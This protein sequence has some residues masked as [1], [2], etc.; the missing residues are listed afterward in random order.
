MQIQRKSVKNAINYTFIALTG[1]TFAVI[2]YFIFSSWTSSSERIITEIQRNINKRIF[3]QV[4]DFL[5]IP[6]KLAQTN[7]ALLENDL[8]DLHNRQKRDMYFAGIIKE[9]DEDIY[10]VS[11]G[12][13]SREYFGARRNIQNEIEVYENTPATR[14]NSL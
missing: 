4:D 14:G 2:G 8:I 12:T 3:N 9:T 10:S 7:K 11:Y 6:I 1:F 5:N 13:E